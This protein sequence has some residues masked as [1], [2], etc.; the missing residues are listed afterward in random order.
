MLVCRITGGIAVLNTL[1]L[2]YMCFGV[3][4]VVI[5]PKKCVNTALSKTVVHSKVGYELTG[6]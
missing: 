1:H 4:R 5:Q 3:E 6:S 2:L